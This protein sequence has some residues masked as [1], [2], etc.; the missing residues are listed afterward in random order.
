MPAPP[1]VK[2]II[3]CELKKSEVS[4]IRFWSNNISCNSGGNFEKRLGMPEVTMVA[5]L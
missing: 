3:N 5:T 4:Y 2:S 1:M